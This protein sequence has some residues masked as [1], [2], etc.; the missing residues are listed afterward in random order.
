MVVY[1][2]VKPYNNIRQKLH[3]IIQDKYRRWNL[4]DKEKHKEDDENVV[5]NFE[6]KFVHFCFQFMSNAIL[7]YDTITYHSFFIQH[8]ISTIWILSDTFTYEITLSIKNT[9]MNIVINVI[10]LS[11]WLLAESFVLSIQP[12]LAVLIKFVFDRK[13]GLKFVHYF[14]GNRYF[15]LVFS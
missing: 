2:T 1:K 4:H 6:G 8:S 3:A 13:A 11:L 7:F 5:G 9:V 15:E 12:L 10:R 14:F